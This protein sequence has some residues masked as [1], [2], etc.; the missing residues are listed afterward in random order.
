MCRVGVLDRFR[1][2]LANLRVS[3]TDRC[4]LRCH[5]C[6]PERDYVWL[7]RTNILT[8]E[9]IERLV[10]VFVSLGTS[11]VRLTGGEPLLRKNLPDLIALLAEKPALTDLAL[12]TNGV[13]LAE[14]VGALRA[15]G[16][17]RITVSLDTLKNDRFL[18]LTRFDNLSTVL[19]GL[20]CAASAGFDS[21][22]IDTVVIR[23]MNDDE[24]VPI[25]EHGRALGVEVR[26]IEYMDVGGATQWSMRDVLSREEILRQLASYYGPILPL[27]ERT[28]APADR[29]TL[30]DGTVFGIIS[31]T[32][33]PFCGQCDRSRLTADGLWYRCLYAPTGTDLRGPLRADANQAELRDL[34]SADWLA[35]DDRGA[36]DRLASSDRSTLI[37]VE[38]LQGEPHLEMH[39][40]GG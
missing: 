18:A 17:P 34:I 19:H 5:Y 14:Q 31:S 2:P 38:T 32:T 15:A 36:E 13:L 4:N 9:E 8:F 40:R 28:A 33:Q 35:R 21:V 10:D 6:M 27:E 23:G 25:L 20:E 29:F 30:P 39:T 1:R 22:K 24:L 26:F 37:S 11:K 16:L 3:V 12:T 7:P